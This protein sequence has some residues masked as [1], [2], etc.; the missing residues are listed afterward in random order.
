M[1]TPVAFFIFNRPRETSLVFDRIREARPP[2]LLIVADGARQH[3]AGEDQLVSDT[4]AVVA[5]IDWPCEVRR[6]YADQNLGCGERVASGLDWVFGLVPEAIVL[7]DD[8]LPAPTFFEFME[9]MLDRYRD[10]ERVGMISGMNYSPAPDS[11]A[12][13]I[14]TNFFAVWGWASWARAWSSYDGSMAGWPGMR[15]TEALRGIF[16]NVGLADW[17]SSM[18]DQVHAGEVD[19]WDVQWV[20]SCLR[21]HQL[22]VAPSVNLVSNIG[23]SGTHPGR[24]SAALGLTTG[25]FT[26]EVEV[27]SEAMIPDFAY[28]DRLFSAFIDRGGPISQRIRAILRG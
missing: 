5:E 25:V 15:S 2:R 26:A 22:C 8:C 7:E 18:C 21:Q 28:E 14:F 19:T 16:R 17:L 6:D 4:R 9:S 27:A 1:K 11:L 10:D 24:D 3:V 13:H 23:Y 20:Y 12:G